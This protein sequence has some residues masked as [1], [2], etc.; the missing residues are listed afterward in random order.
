LKFTINM[1][2]ETKKCRVTIDRGGRNR[3]ANT[4]GQVMLLI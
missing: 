3:R 4:T 1:K 2:Q